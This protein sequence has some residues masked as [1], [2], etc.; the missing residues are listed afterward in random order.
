MK[1]IVA[2]AFILF[3]LL[4]SACSD[5]ST[6][7]T[8]SKDQPIPGTY[9]EYPGNPDIEIENVEKS[10]P[11]EIYATDAATN[12][13]KG[14]L[15]S[16]SGIVKSRETLDDA[17]YFVIETDSG[18]VA[19]L[20]MLSYNISESLSI[21]IEMLRPYFPLPSTGEQ[22][23]VT[24]QYL[25]RS[26]SLNLAMFLYGGQNY[27]TEAYVLA[28]LESIGSNESTSSPTQTASKETTAPAEKGSKEN[29]YKA[30]MYK[31]GSEL[32]AGEY[33]FFSS[34]SQRAYV[35]ISSDSNQDNI[36][37]NENFS[38]SLFITVADGQYLQAKR[39]YFVKASDYTVAINDDGSFG[40]GMYRV[41]IDIPAG[42]Y[43]LTAGED[44][45]YWCLYSS[46]NIP[47]DI[48]D[49]DN[50]EGSAYVT[51]H[52]GQYLIIKRCTAKP[53]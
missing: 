47:F 31:V 20:D 8:T 13:L 2:F 3:L 23:C 7:P 17:T 28:A 38:N 18:K 11:K 9:K 19:V 27:Y 44:R 5:N 26:N 42:E 21:D 53:V 12:G 14:N 39:C 48:D 46:S 16:I 35:C 34:G 4:L 40:E 10:L 45:A 29:P 43:K 49:N 32:P 6:L 24:A 51:V 22:V 41:G 52:Q 36:I 37:E 25:G 1:R 30:G 33:L 50:F 15:Y